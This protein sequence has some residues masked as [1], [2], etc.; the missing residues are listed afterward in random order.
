MA[1]GIAVP[2]VDAPDGLDAALAALLGG[3][4]KLA[5]VEAPGAG[6]GLLVERLLRAQRERQAF[7]ALV[8]GADA[9]DPA[10]VEDPCL[11]EHLLWVRCGGLKQALHC[12]DVLLRD[13]NFPLVVVDL[14]DVPAR[15]L[16]R[17]PLHQWYRLQQVCRSRGTGVLL[18]REAC[19]SAAQCR[20]RIEARPA[21]ADLEAPRRSLE[22]GL[23]CAVLRQAGGAQGLRL[24]GMAGRELVELSS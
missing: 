14:L 11:L 17:L 23:Q 13:E 12:A 8:D 7:A 18:V 10:T 3:G 15:E 5:E 9:F 4:G 6:A 2:A 20:I 19:V 24:I 1:A 21:L 16:K 22:P